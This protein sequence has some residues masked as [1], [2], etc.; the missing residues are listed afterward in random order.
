[1][2]LKYVYSSVDI[3]NHRYTN[4]QNC[5]L[6]KKK[7]D[8]KTRIIFCPPP[9]P[10]PKIVPTAL[11]NGFIRNVKQKT[12]GRS[13]KTLLHLQMIPCQIELP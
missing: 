10:N 12:K 7:C 8:K 9:P 6:L 11:V 13:A 2:W 1:M 5:I 3:G 4:E